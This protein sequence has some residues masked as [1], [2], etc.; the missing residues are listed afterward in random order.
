MSA[1]KGGKNP[2]RKD[3]SP[4]EKKTLLR[5]NKV[6]R[7][8]HCSDFSSN[9]TVEMFEE[10]TK[11]MWDTM[12][13]ETK[14]KSKYEYGQCYSHDGSGVTS[15]HLRRLIEFTRPQQRQPSCSLDRIKYYFIYLL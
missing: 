1:G 3:L 9:E 11:D 2:K 8:T 10:Q 7:T 14:K 13:T 12:S 15:R 6:A 5:I 4:S